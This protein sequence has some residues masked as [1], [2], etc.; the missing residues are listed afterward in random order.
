MLQGGGI[1]FYVCRNPDLKCTVVERVHRTIRD[2]IYKYFKFKNTYR[3]I[4]VLHKFVNVYN[5]TVHSTTVMAPSRVTDSDVL[6]IWKRTEEAGKRGCV[7]VAKAAATFR[8]RQQVRISKEKMRFAKAAEKNFSTE[9]FRV[10]KIFERRSRA[11]DELEDL[12]DTP[13]DRQFNREELN[14]VRITERTA[15]KIDKILDKSV[16]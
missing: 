10:A 14:L 6:A 5:D 11:V 4:D 13:I 12:N 1:Q 2:R 16:R 8:V 7:S 3:Y 15:Y 9:I